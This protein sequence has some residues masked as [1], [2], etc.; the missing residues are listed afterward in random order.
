M[1]FFYSEMVKE[2]HKQHKSYREKTEIG[3][4]NPGGHEKN[5]RFGKKSGVWKFFW[6]LGNFSGGWDF[7]RWLSTSRKKYSGGSDLQ[8][9]TLSP[10]SS[11]QAAMP[12]LRRLQTRRPGVPGYHLPPIQRFNSTIRARN[13]CVDFLSWKQRWHP[14]NSA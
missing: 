5:W 11:T 4:K 14:C 9:N 7:F 10:G 6:R 13:Y 12:P 3:K 8:K 2:S 1:L